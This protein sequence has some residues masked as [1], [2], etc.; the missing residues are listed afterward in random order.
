MQ[1]VAPSLRLRLVGDVLHRT[2]THQPPAALTRARPNVNDV[3]GTANGVFVML[4]H[5][6]GVALLAEQMQGVQQNLVV[7]CVQAN[8]GLVQHIA[9]TLQVAAQL[10]RQA[11]ALRLT[12]AQR[13]CATVEREV[14]QAHL[15]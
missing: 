2:L 15:L 3:V 9:N 6:Q 7:A 11:N 1:Q 10:R 13:R 5:H 12:A 4:H 14:V 8:R